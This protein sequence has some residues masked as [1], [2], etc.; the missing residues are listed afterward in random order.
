MRA[1]RQI[2]SDGTVRLSVAAMV[3][4]QLVMT[5]T[6]VITPLHMAHHAHGTKAISWVIMAHT[7]GMFGLSSMTSR[8]SD[9]FGRVRIVIAGALVLAVS[10][11]LTPISNQLPMLAFAL[12]L[13]GLGWNF[14][15][16]AGS[17]LL[18]GAVLPF[19]RGRAQGITEMMVSL[20]AATGSLGTGT[21]FAE[22]GIVAVSA[23]GLGFSLA[24]MGWAIRWIKTR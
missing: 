16:I 11:V 6:M 23:I 12:F 22:G 9:Y 19:E 3:I 13:L 1:L 7:L 14:C 24:L 18:S 4:G 20:A 8:L 5:L 10:A 15:F 2:F 17:A 21:V